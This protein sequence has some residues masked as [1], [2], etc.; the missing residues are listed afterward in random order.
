M[1]IDL[2][3]VLVD[4]QEKALQF[5]TQKLGF[6]KMADI[7]VGEFRWLTV[8][9]SE[10]GG[11][12]ELLLEPMGFAEAR[13]YQ[14]ALYDAGTPYTA[15]RTEDIDQEYRLLKG[16]GVIFRGEPQ[17]M[18]PIKSVLFEDTCGNLINLVQALVK[19]G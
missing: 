14:K 15:F 1:R 17:E 19:P 4:D 13:V 2:T 16:R 8:V 18:G 6:R 5:Y 11:G 3:N 7:P 10:S 9:S 12:M